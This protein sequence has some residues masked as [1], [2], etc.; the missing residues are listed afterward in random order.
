MTPV[1]SIILPFYKKTEAFA[2]TV[3]RNKVFFNPNYEIVLLLDAPGDAQE[4]V[5]IARANNGVRW[6][7]FENPNPHDWRNPAKPLNVGIR[8]ARSDVSLIL[9]PET[10]WLTDV[11]GELLAHTQLNPG[12]YHY[13]NITLSQK[14]EEISA[15]TF[16]TAEQWSCGSLCCKTQHLRDVGGYDE[17]LDG[18]GA[19]DDNIRRRLILNNIYAQNHPSTKLAHPKDSSPHRKYS[20]STRARLKDLVNPTEAVVNTDNWGR[21]FDTLIYRT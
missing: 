14:F 16:D 9:S 1:L 15:E 6:S 12:K 18:W 7:I 4:V 8:K 2:K 5:Q 10:L 20:T 13:G 11:P 19:D 17:S 3:E 21:D